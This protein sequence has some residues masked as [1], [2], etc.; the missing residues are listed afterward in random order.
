MN[1]GTGHAPASRSIRHWLARRV[2]RPPQSIFGVLI[3]LVGC[4]VPRAPVDPSGILE[5]LAPSPGFSPRQ[6]PADWVISGSADARL[7]V[8]TLDGVPS[9]RIDPGEDRVLLARRTRAALLVSPY[10]SWAWNMEA[11]ANDHHPVGLIVGFLGGNREGGAGSLGRWILPTAGLPRHDRALLLTWGG[12]ALQRGSMENGAPEKVGRNGTT[13]GYVVR[14]GRENAGIWWLDTVDLSA[15]YA[16][17]WPGD[18]VG[19]A[20]I[21]FVGVAAAA[22]GHGR[23]HIS[24]IKLSR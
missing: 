4:A 9:L 17:A 19:R 5:I 21:A 7:A 6:P 14:G 18:D 15:L 20:R 22:D 13:V 2:A 3:V 23:A 10:L 24:G 8:V 12:S 16:D 11:S 1:R